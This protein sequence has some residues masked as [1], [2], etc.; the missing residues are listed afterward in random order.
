MGYD[1]YCK[2]ESHPEADEAKR[3]WEESG[4]WDQSRDQALAA[5]EEMSRAERNSGAYFRLNIWGMDRYREAMW[6]IEGMVN[7][8]PTPRFPDFDPER[9]ESDDEYT[10][11]YDR[12]ALLVK[13]RSPEAPGIPLYKLGSNDGWLV[14]PDECAQAVAAWERYCD[15]GGGQVFDDPDENAYWDAW[16]AFLRHC[17]DHG[18]FEVW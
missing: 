1:M 9:Y 6:D 7:D 4:K 10:A 3:K 2:G 18:G 17:R 14:V 16:I 5:Y 13:A 12:Q 15:E 11:H 8:V